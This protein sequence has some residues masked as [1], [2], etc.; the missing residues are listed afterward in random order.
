[1]FWCIPYKRDCL[2]LKLKKTL[3]MKN[4]YNSVHDYVTTRL[5]DHAQIT[6]EIASVNIAKVYNSN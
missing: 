5:E 2:L 4:Q 6:L 3:H 1:M